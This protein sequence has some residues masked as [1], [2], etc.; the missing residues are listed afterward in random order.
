MA[1]NTDC[2]KTAIITML[3]D[4]K[5]NVVIMNEQI[6]NISRKIKSIKNQIKILD[7]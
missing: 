3:K 6:E 2:F 4:I 7:L 5:K 1:I